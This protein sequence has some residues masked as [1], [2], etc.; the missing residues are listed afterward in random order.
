MCQ[1][2]LHTALTMVLQITAGYK[3]NRKAGYKVNPK[4]D[5]Q[6]CDLHF[7]H[8]KSAET[9]VFRTCQVSVIELFVEIFNG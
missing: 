8:I 4:P 9:D 1:W 5:L 6:F 7:T 2:F 3:V